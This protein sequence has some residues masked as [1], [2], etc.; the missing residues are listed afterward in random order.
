MQSTIYRTH[1]NQSILYFGA[2]V[3]GDLDEISF[4]LSIEESTAQTL[5][6][7]DYQGH[8]IYIIGSLDGEDE[9]LSV[10]CPTEGKFVIGTGQA[11]KDVIDVT[12]GLQEPV[13]GEVFDLYSQLGDV[14]VKLASAVPEYL[15]EQIPEQIPLGPINVGLSSFR[16]IEYATLTLSENEAIIDA[17]ARLEFTSED[18]ARTSQQLLST[19]IMAAKA[20]LPDP[21]VRKL[22]SKVQISRSGS[23]ISLAVAL[24]VSE[25][26]SLIS[27]MAAQEK[28]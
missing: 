13:S 2:L 17:V 12:V 1:I 11:V 6:R 23:S 25:I 20:L 27:A 4:I 7:S 19:G 15:T 5:Q 8:V 16:D 26:E 21:A 18:S 14:P 9:V 10:A 22:L 3:E 24:T 28:P